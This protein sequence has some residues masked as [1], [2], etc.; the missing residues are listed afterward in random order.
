MSHHLNSLL[1][2]MNNIVSLSFHVILDSL[3]PCFLSV[4]LSLVQDRAI[5]LGGDM[6]PYLD[7]LLSSLQLFELFFE[8]L[9]QI[10]SQGS[11]AS[12]SIFATAGCLR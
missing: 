2:S 1:V 4:L 8:V 6:L 9:D 12:G 3:I 5:S 11:L 10:F 7:V